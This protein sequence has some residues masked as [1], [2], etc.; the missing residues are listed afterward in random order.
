M[1]ININPL[2]RFLND[3]ANLILVMVTAVYAFL[4]YRMVSLTKKQIVS[5]IKVSKAVVKSGLLARRSKKYKDILLKEVVDKNI[6]SFRDELI[7]FRVS[8]D[9]HNSSPG[10]GCI[11][12]P[13]LLLKF[14]KEGFKLELK[15]GNES[16]GSRDTI[17]MRGGDFEKKDLDYFLPYNKEFLKNLQKCPGQLEYFIRYKDNLNKEHIIKA[18]KVEPLV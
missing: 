14:R 2:L 15:N 3:Y 5:D 11:E 17:F 13:K 10:N 18:D 7:S 8:I 9:I 16:T 4:T 6:S 12:Q 1:D